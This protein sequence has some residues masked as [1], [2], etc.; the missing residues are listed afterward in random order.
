MKNL[1]FRKLLSCKNIYQ[2]NFSLFNKLPNFKN[3]SGLQ[4]NF[5]RINKLSFCTLDRLNVDKISL[6][7]L[8]EKDK[9]FDLK[10]KE[11][12]PFNK[13]DYIIEFNPLVKWEE[14]VLKSEIPVVVDCY[15]M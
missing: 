4:S 1:Q 2:N 13:E 5:L 3:I 12:K 6:T 15:A 8:D 10:K 11:E 14:E 7:K 9:P